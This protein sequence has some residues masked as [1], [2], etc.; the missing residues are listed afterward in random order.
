MALIVVTGPPFAGK[1]AYARDEI[2]R[3]ESDGELGLILIGFTETYQAIAPGPQ[4]Q[5]RDQAVS[6]SGAPR[7]AGY[8]YATAIN[9]AA[10]RELS[11]F[12]TTDSPRR[13]VEIAD[14]IGAAAIIDIAIGVEQIARRAES[15][16]V[17]LSRT[18]PRAGRAASVRRCRDAGVTYLRER[19]VLAGRARVA[20]RRP[21]GWEVSGNVAAFD[22]AAFVRGLTPGGRTVRDELIAAGRPAQPADILAALLADRR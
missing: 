6:D 1:S 17:T 7:L 5:F 8:L 3:R 13:A 20:T 11:G 15:H 18:V 22:E 12:V 9:E 10:E 16:M 19:A 4:S 14:R 21:R 2:A